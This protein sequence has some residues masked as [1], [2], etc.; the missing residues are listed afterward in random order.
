MAPDGHR[1]IVHITAC[2]LA[3]CEGQCLGAAFPEPEMETWDGRLWLPDAKPLRSPPQPISARA[4]PAGRR[5]RR[6]T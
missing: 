6:W 5:H 3:G 4:L 2:T 1:L